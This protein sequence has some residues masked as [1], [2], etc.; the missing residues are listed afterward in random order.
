MLT[1][2]IVLLLLVLSLLTI[3]NWYAGRGPSIASA[4]VINMDA[5]A[6]R[7]HE[8]QANAAAAGLEIKRWVAVDGSK[9]TSD[10]LP[11]LGISKYI[12]KYSQEHKQHG[13]L[14]CFLSHRG[15]LRHCEKMAV[16][17][18]SAH[19]IFEDDAYIPPDFKAQWQRICADLPADWDIVQLGVTFPN[20]RCA[21]GRIHTHLNDRGNVG[22]FAYVVRHSALPKINSYTKYMYDPM[23]VMIRNKWR[24]WNIYIVWPQLCPHND[25]GKSVIISGAK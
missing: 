14:G 11:R 10:D 12:Y 25:H 6:D 2:Y 15:L 5:H 17:S 1:Q 18:D 4:H 9:I 22:G 13:L 7:L 21:R 19:F 3:L 24:D 16:S 20:L 8:F 23:D